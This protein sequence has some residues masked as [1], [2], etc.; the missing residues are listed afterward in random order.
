[1]YMSVQY[2]R[3]IAA[4]AI[5]IKHASQARGT[6]LAHALDGG[7][8]LFFIISGFVMVASTDGRK[9]GP[10]E[11][12]T[13]RARRILPM[14]WVTLALVAALGLGSGSEAD[15]LRSVA[16]VP[17]WVTY[18]VGSVSWGVGWTL[19][20]EACFY[21]VFAIGLALRS[22]RF[23]VYAMSGLVLT[24]IVFGRSQSPLLNTLLHPLLMEFLL[25]MIVA[26]CVLS[27]TALPPGLIVAGAILYV[28]GSFGPF[29][30]DIHPVLRGIPLA[31]IVAGVV[32]FE[33]RRGIPDIPLLRLLGDASY[34]IYLLHYVAI[35]LAW[36]FMPKASWWMLTASAGVAIGCISYVLIEKPLLNLTKRTAKPLPARV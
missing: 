5:V 27:R 29:S 11:F 20:F 31:L 24:G 36:G 12:L 23:T 1:M 4:L 22:T 28:L 26:K 14:W 2:F 10:V 21:V 16:L 3:G 35:M 32:G 34:S 25:G 8:D 33:T 19:V 6:P 17:S 15:W 13:R 18:G 7:V 9:M 30:Y